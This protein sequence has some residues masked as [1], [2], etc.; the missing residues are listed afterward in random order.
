MTVTLHVTSC[1][2]T[3]AVKRNCDMDK[4]SDVKKLPPLPWNT[5]LVAQTS[6]KHCCC[7]PGISDSHKVVVSSGDKWMD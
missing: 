3:L 7:V 4:M 5:D 6:I 2:L 1:L